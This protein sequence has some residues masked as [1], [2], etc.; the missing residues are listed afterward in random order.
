MKSI[1]MTFFLLFWMSLLF[2]EKKRNNKTN[3]LC[4]AIFACKGQTKTQEN[5]IAHEP[6]VLNKQ[7]ID[8]SI[9]HTHT[10]QTGTTH[11]CMTKI[12]KANEI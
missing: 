7:S 12:M 2:T 10:K 4:T 5:P 6:F 8:Q 9:D 11:C 3:T 1:N